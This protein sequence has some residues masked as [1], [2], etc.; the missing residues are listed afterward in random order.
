MSRPGR[1]TLSSVYCIPLIKMNII[2]CSRLDKKAVSDTTRNSV[3]Y[4][5]DRRSEIL[6]VNVAKWPSNGLFVTIISPYSRHIAAKNAGRSSD[7]RINKIQTATLGTATTLRCHRS[8]HANMSVINV[9]MNWAQYGMLSPNFEN[10]QNFL[11]F[12]QA[13]HTRSRRKGS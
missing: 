6:F 3:C 2:S 7:K 5:T 9:M 4:F 1:L 12:M 13:N 11:T 10:T 8:G